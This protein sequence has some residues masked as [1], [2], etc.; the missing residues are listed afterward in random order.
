M[1]IVF[2]AL[3][4]CALVPY[5]ILRVKKRGLEGLLVKIGVSMCFILT[6][7]SPLLGEGAP[8]FPRL[9]FGVLAGLVCGL[10]GD[11][12]LDL[13][14][15]YPQHKDAYVFAGFT[16]FLVGH[17]F[18]VGGLWS[19]YGF[20]L[21]KLWIAA[22]AG[23]LLVVAVLLTEKPM[24][25]RY[26]RFKGISLGYGFVLAFMVATAWSCY[27]FAGGGMDPGRITAMLMG[28][29]GALFL[30]SD[31]ILSGTFF[32]KGFDK[33]VDYALNYTLYYGAQFLI[34]WSLAAM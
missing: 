2:T 8:L 27:A 9:R 3:G 17:F 19:A 29:G 15:M 25:L 24:K 31:M 16:A 10:L 5:I 7:A 14:D 32:G 13:K 22:L 18:Y 20:S 21:K 11:I 6:A 33:P 30:A 12:L 26:G 1:A 4:G 23:L 34:A 28:I